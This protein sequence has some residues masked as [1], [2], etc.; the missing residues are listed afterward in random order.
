MHNLFAVVSSTEGPTQSTEGAQPV[1]KSLR[2]R[3]EE[4]QVMAYG[5][6]ILSIALPFNNYLLGA[7]DGRAACCCVDVA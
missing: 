1:P 5:E 6:G 2:E 7:N 4:K 3:F